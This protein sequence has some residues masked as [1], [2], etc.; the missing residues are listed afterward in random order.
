MKV[1]KI[2]ETCLYVR[3]LERA[4]KFY[5]ETLELQVIGYVPD[6]HVFFQAGESVLLLFNPDDSKTKDSPPA[7]YAEGKQHYAFEVASPDYKDVKSWILSKGIRITDEVTWASGSQSFY[8]EDTEGNVLELFPIV[9]YGPQRMHYDLDALSDR[10]CFLI[11]V[12]Q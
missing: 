2:K 8:F 7:H 4:K 11:I 9:V 10:F 1:K 6:K 5:E 12:S 3:N